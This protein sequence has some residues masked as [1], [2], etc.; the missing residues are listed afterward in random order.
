VF[1][2]TITEY[3]AAGVWPDPYDSE[4]SVR[5]LRL[6]ATNRAIHQRLGLTPL[7]VSTDRIGIVA[8][9]C[10]RLLAAMH[11]QL[12]EPVDRSG[13]GRILEVYP[14]AAAL[15]SWQIN[16]GNT[17]D[18]GSYKGDSEPARTR[19]EWVLEQIS[20]STS[21]WLEI[22]PKVKVV[23]DDCLEALTA[24][25][26]PERRTATS[27]SR[28]TTPTDSPPQRAGSACRSPSPSRSWA[29][30]ANPRGSRRGRLK[31]SSRVPGFAFQRQR[32]PVSRFHGR[33]A[34]QS[35]IA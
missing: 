15:R 9:H 12:G 29:S 6:R 16:P 18:P 25:S 34:G 5:N 26:S 21:G 30:R 24:R 1:I 11:H 17:E 2:Q 28:S 31:S 20:C 13:Q 22:N 4:T 33:C 14:A 8:M 23:C 35:A 10:A 19:R 32:P 27:S 3:Q 7:T